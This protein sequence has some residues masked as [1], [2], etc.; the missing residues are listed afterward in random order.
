MA[1]RDK[2]GDDFLFYHKHLPPV[3]IQKF[4][5]IELIY[6]ALTYLGSYTKLLIALLSARTK[7]CLHS[8]LYTISW[9]T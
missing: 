5:E 6:F 1:L 8:P 4:I 2:N 3:L 7:E 9:P